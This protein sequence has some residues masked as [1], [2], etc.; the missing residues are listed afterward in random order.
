MKTMPQTIRD[1]VIKQLRYLVDDPRDTFRPTFS[2]EHW[3]NFYA[4]QKRLEPQSVS[5]KI[6]KVVDELLAAG[7]L[8]P[9]HFRRT[10]V[11]YINA[12]K[13]EEVKLAIG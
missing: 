1:A 13:L 4:E 12:I 3:T 2:T 11:F 10:G 6:Q 9:G 5:P 8:E 7:V